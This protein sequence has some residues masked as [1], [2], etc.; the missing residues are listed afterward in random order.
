MCNVGR[1]GGR[2]GSVPSFPPPSPGLWASLEVALS[3]QA[4]LFAEGTLRKEKQCR[5]PH[6]TTRLQAGGQDQPWWEAGGGPLACDLRPF[7]LGVWP[8][9]SIK[10]FLHSGALS[11]PAL[12]FV[13]RSDSCI[14]VLWSGPL[15]VCPSVC[16]YDPQGTWAAS[17][18]REKV[19]TG[20]LCPV[21]GRGCLGGSNHGLTCVAQKYLLRTCECDCLWK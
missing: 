21:G 14:I 4:L 17:R 11:G 20:P 16:G 19:P 5:A 7:P 12:F 6:V 2:R 10:T 18:P 15:C 8:K 13:L 1:G 9:P 3:Q